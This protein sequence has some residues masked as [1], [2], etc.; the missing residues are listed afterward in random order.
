MALAESNLIETN[1]DKSTI[2]SGMEY[3]KY[4]CSGLEVSRICVGC[5]GFGSLD[6]WGRR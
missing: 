5:M 6:K 2:G 1:F 3:V 4:G